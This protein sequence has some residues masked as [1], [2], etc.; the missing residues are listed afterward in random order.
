MTIRAVAV[1]IPARNEAAL[2]PA[3]LASVQAARRRLEVENPEISTHV[4]VVLDSC[5]D[6]TPAIVDVAPGVLAVTVS[7]QR[8][9]AARAA[10]VEAVAERTA[11]LSG[12][13]VWIANTDADTIVPSH[14]LTRQVSLA[15]H[16]FDLVVGTA[17]P[18]RSEI[19]P[20][21]LAGWWARHTMADGHEHVHGA[22]LGIRLATYLA[23]GGFPPTAAHEDVHLVAAARAQPCEWIATDRTRVLTSGRRASRT[24]GGFGSYLQSLADSVADD[25]ESG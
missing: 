5:T 18:R 23:A 6:A 15:D 8:V 25:V 1:V 19:D 7:A 11:P 13:R 4:V 20:D 24:V 21:V 17:E 16:G 14:W 22:N 2:L 10:G 12:D 9:G 3:C